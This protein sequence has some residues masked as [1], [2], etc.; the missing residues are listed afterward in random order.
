MS[1][2]ENKNLTL[3][4]GTQILSLKY[5]NEKRHI[6]IKATLSKVNVKINRME[7]S[8]WTYHNESSFATLLATFFSRKFNFSKR[9]SYE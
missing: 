6:S 8:K 2:L 7:S 5:Y 1:V 3:N 4:T 9:T